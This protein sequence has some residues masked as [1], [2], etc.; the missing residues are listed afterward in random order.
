MHLLTVGLRLVYLRI[1][2]RERDKYL[3]RQAIA[4]SLAEVGGI[5]MKLGQIIADSGG[6]KEYD[7]LLTTGC[8]RPLS[9]MLPVL[10]DG[11][12]Q[13]V[14]K[15]FSTIEESSN[16]ASLGQVHRACLL[17]GERVAVKIQYPSIAAV[18]NSELKLA[19]LMPGLG[20]VKKWA[21]DLD[22]YRLAL[23]TNMGRELD[24]SS[25]AKRQ[26]K[27]KRT[28]HVEGLVVPR[29][30]S[31]YCSSRVL[32]QSW[33]EGVLLDDV[34][35]WPAL[36]RMHIARVLMQTL[37]QSLFQTGELH[38][39]PH[40]GN[41]FYRRTKQKAEVVLLDYGC[42]ITIPEKARLAMLKLILELRDGNVELVSSCF[43]AMGFDARKLSYIVEELNLLAQVLFKPFL[44]DEPFETDKWEIKHT[45]ENL[46]GEKKW[47]FRSAGPADIF[48][49]MRAF[50]GLTRQLSILDASL[51]WWPLLL[52]TINPQELVAASEFQPEPFPAELM[53]GKLDFSPQAKYLKVYI[54]YQDR[55][56][57]IS[58]SMP[59]LAALDLENVIPA[60]ILEKL[61]SSGEIDMG[62]LKQKLLESRLQPQVLLDTHQGETNYLVSL[63]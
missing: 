34:K 5:S 23:S 8:A 49:I 53:K 57:P 61:N 45:I 32:V 22:A 3:A 13:S 37:F 25:E 55:R 52:K 26:D 36:D 18:V 62:K 33:E 24:Y 46:L 16:A 56:E 17:N 7:S 21:I 4:D 50:Q 47:W 30:Y 63:E 51:P 48:L 15:V 38:G 28:L 27:M 41:I 1:L 58:I 31:E 20:P 42:T 39:D 35:E 43:V 6:A 19:G 29:V 59:A 10:E 12:Q 54:E 9:E 44:V 40:K 2:H 60:E 14:E 11:L